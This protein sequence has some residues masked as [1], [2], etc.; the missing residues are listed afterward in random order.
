[1]TAIDHAGLEVIDA[2]E[3]LELIDSVPVGRVAWVDQGSPVILPVNHRRVGGVIVFRTA[4]GTKLGAAMMSAAVAFEVDDFD[5]HEHTGWSVL[6]TGIAD[7]VEDEAEIE[8]Y[9]AL[10]L[11]PWA[12]SEERPFWVRIR[13]DMI[14]GRRT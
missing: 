10:G 3:C 6:V 8:K 4:S 1:M 12:D 11:R 7:V 9:E 14:T 5:R 2:G 13:A